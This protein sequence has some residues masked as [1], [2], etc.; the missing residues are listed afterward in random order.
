LRRSNPSQRER[1]NQRSNKEEEKRSG[2]DRIA[3]H[4]TLLNLFN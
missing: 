3:K 4:M 2:V 1:T